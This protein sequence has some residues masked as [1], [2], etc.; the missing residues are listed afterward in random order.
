MSAPPPGYPVGPQPGGPT[1]AGYPPP[2][3]GTPPAYGPPPGYG[4]PP[5]YGPPPGYGAPPS[6]GPPPGHGQPPQY[7][8]PQLAPGAIKPGII[9]LRPLSLSDIF[10]GA[11]GYIRTNPKAT[12]GLTAIVVVVMQIISLIAT[13]GPI[14]AYGRFS[15]DRSAEM[16]WGVVG[17]WLRAAK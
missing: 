1:P 12:L 2:G 6:Y 7:G 16:S 4:P 10:N 9:P 8:S 3:Y 14:A 5:A 17:A 11:V 13:V 15:S